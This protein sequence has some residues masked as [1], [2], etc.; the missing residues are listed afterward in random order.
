MTRKEQID[1]MLKEVL[2]DFVKD[3]VVDNRS[4]IHEL[5]KEAM[6]YTLLRI[7]PKDL[8]F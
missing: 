1:Q 7:N 3:R 6:E 2:E 8:D 5:I 4:A